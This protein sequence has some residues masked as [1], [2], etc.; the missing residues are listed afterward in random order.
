VDL[1]LDAIRLIADQRPDVRAIVVGDGKEADALKAHAARLKL[2][3][4]VDFVGQRSDIEN[5]LRQARVFIMTSDS[6]GLS[7]AL[8]EAMLCGLPAV[9]SDVGDLGDLVENGVNGYLVPERA[10]S[11]FAARMLELV[12]DDTRHAQFARAARAGAERFELS[13]CV[14]LWDQA[15]SAPVHSKG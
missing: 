1:F 14:K 4:H 8:I 2:D 6:E 13:S 7:L 9:V 12:S 5:W 10:A 11:A 15:L 3:G